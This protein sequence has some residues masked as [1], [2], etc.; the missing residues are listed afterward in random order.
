VVG[1]EHTPD[2]P[3]AVNG[4][5]GADKGQPLPHR[6]FPPPGGESCILSQGGAPYGSRLI[7]GGHLKMVKILKSLPDSIRGLPSGNRCIGGLITYYKGAPLKKKNPFININI[8]NDPP[9]CFI[10]LFA[11]YSV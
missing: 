7:N 5:S 2:G 1:P 9:F 10:L 6:D 3:L 4:G 11:K 8:Q